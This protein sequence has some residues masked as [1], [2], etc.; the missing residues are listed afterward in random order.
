MNLNMMRKLRA[1]LLVAALS[2]SSAFAQKVKVGYDK[3]VDFSRYTSYTWAKPT[4]P[5]TRPLLYV[6]LVDSIDYELKAKGLSRMDDKGD[7]ILI[8]GG[9][10]EFGLNNAVG[11]PILSTYSGPPPTIDATMWTGA[12]GPSNLMAPYVPEGTLM[13]NFVDRG[14]NKVIWV[15]TVTQK[16]EIENKRKSLDLI[17]KAVTKLLKEFPPKK[18]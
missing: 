9:G 16:L 7:L 15:G 8:P 12:G 10:M 6:S 5:P 18:K 13:L 3:G 14:S 4:M 11:A 2:I 17:D 1:C